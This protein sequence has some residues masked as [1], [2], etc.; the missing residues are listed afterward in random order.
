MYKIIRSKEVGYN[1]VVSELRKNY[2]NIEQ[3]HYRPGEAQG[4]PG[5]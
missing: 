3:T 4:V 5:G 1:E 2:V